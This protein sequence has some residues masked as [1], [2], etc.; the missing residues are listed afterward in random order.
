[1]AAAGRLAFAAAVRMVDGVHGDAAVVRALAQPALAAGLSEG[2]VLVLDVAELA[3]GGHAHH[4]DLADL[5]RGHLDLRV[6]AFLGPG[7]G[8]AA[9]RAHHLPALAVAQLDVVDH[10]ADGDRPEGKRVAGQDVRGLAAEDSG[11]HGQAFRPEDVALLAVRVVQQGQARGP[12]GVVFDGRDLGRDP[13]LV[14]LEVDL[15]VALLVPAP[16]EAHGDAPAVVAS[17]R[18]LEGLRERLLR[19]ALRE[20]VV[21]QVGHEAATRRRGVEIL[22][23]HWLS[24]LLGVSG[25]VFITHAWSKNSTIFSPFFRTT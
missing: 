2:N 16:D 8:L 23:C 13:R 14:A 24:F 6:V 10:G 9:R 22:Q 21:G 18:L 5:A 11:A 12:V 20:L 15:A 19:R 3:H 4:R 1:M 7:L 25:L 17:A